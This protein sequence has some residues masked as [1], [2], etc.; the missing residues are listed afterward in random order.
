[1]TAF[2]DR[3]RQNRRSEGRRGQARPTAEAEPERIG[4]YPAALDEDEY[5]REE[6]DGEG[7]GDE[8]TLGAHQMPG[9]A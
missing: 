7:E 3:R 1:M 6:E 5:R 2:L 9:G 4:E 8:I